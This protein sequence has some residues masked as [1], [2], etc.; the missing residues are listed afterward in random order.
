MQKS[1]GLAECFL[2][3]PRRLP[4]VES[5]LVIR[6]QHSARSVTMYLEWSF[7]LWHSMVLFLFYPVAVVVRYGKSDGDVRAIFYFSV[8][9]FQG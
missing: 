1:I 2:S 3:L 4:L 6:S 9:F 5:M 7:C 8:P